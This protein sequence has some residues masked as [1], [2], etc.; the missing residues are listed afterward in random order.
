MK[1]LRFRTQDEGRDALVFYFLFASLLVFPVMFTGCFSKE[2]AVLNKTVLSVNGHD[3][4]TKEFADRLALRLKNFDAL[5]VK[6]EGN[7]DRAKEEIV[8]SFILEIIARD[9][10]DKNGVTVEKKE[11]EAQVADVR[12]KYPDEFSFRRALADENLPAEKW[13]SDIEFSL[14]QKKIF[15]KVTAATPQPAEAE[16]KAFYDANKTQFQTP[17]RVRLRQV[18]LEKEDDAR[19]IYDEIIAGADMEK[20]ARKF[21]IAPEAANGG[22]TGWLDK[23]TL[24]VFEPAFKMPVGAKSKVLKSPYGWH[25]YAVLKKEPETRLSFQDAKAKIRT[26]L[27]E[28]K[29]NEVFKHWLEEQVRKST[30]KRNDAV[31]R[32]IKVTTR[33]S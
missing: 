30:V 17:A 7:L 18:V 28:A 16:M 31:I 20:L 29:T 25:I 27:L 2:R 10:A 14:L 19:R 22:D 4:S 5:H 23:G 32:A 9:Y 33:G 11:I 13:R 12:A 6:D 1:T 21:S 3:V 8:Q 26:R 15:A 24:E